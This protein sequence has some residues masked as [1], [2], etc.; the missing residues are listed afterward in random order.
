[1]DALCFYLRVA[2]NNLK[3]YLSAVAAF[4]IWG[5]FP[6]LLKSLSDYSAGEIL[7]FRILFASVLLVV[8]VMVIRRRIFQKDFVYMRALPSVKRMKTIAG[9]LA[10]GAL[11]TI[12]WL[13]F[14]YTVN[15]VNIRT[16]SFSYLICPVLTAVMGYWLLHEKLSPLQWFAVG[17]CAASCTMI[18]LG[19][20]SELGYSFSTALTYGLYIVLQRRSGELDRISVLSVQIVFSFLVL[21]VAYPYLVANVPVEG[22]FYVRIIIIAAVFTVLPLFLNL[23]ALIKINSATVGILMYINPLINFAIAIFIFHEQIS[24][25]QFIGYAIILLGLVAFNYPYFTKI[26]MALGGDR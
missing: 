18:G 10:G 13:I 3:H 1:M 21:N 11:L 8:I 25:L 22:G 2:M 17:L 20:V 14:I 16:A 24:M 6:W 23:F 19:S 4:T 7:Y 12:N 9:L 26:R 15:N 5:F